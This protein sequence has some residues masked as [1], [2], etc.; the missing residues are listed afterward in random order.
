MKAS[1]KTWHQFYQK[2]GYLFYSVAA[3]DQHIA[4]EEEKILHEMVLEDWVAF[5]TAHDEFGTDAA[6]EIEIVFD[7]IQD[8]G[9]SAD[10][11]FHVF[12]K[13]YKENNG[14]FTDDVNQRIFHTIQRIS[15]S[16]HG[17]NKSEL[18]A[19]TRVHLLLGREKTTA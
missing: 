15:H 10:K 16:F 12:E 19:I 6:Y 2:L 18:T 4:K 14:L 11:A 13:F 5:S 1:E 3:A 7:Y 8:Q 9:L 17:N